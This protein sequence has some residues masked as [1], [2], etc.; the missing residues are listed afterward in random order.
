[1]KLLFFCLIVLFNIPS[2]AQSHIKIVTIKNG[3]TS[4][5]YAEN[6]EVYTVSLL[7]QLELRNMVSSSGTDKIYIV[8][9][10]TKGFRLTELKP[11]KRDGFGY[12][13]HFTN[14]FGDV[15]QQVAEDD[16]D[17]N[18]PYQKGLQF[19]IE[20]GYNGS[21]SHQNE[22]AL[23]FNMPIGTDILAAREGIVVDVVDSFI[24]ACLDVVCNKKANYVLIA[25]ADGTFAN[26]A[27]IQ[28]HGAK[29]AVGDVVNKGELIAVSGNTGYTKG[30]HLHFVVFLPHI[31]GRETL[32]TKFKIGN[33]D[34]S[35][36]LQEGKSYNRR[37]K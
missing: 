13:L 22:N 35:A 9:K 20:Q 17:Y 18:L 28:Y 14:V 11:I 34:N 37:Y 26:Y 24:G 33:G 29:V 10:K 25:H 2:L 36:Y 31:N 3:N 15:N 1:M 27:H 32:A 23:D 21:F 6:N 8:P 30:P 5:L 7:L 19:T 16:Y 12:S 4:V